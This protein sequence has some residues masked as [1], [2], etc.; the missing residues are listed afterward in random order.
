MVGAEQ[1]IRAFQRE[2]QVVRAMARRV[3]RG[4]PPAIAFDRRAVRQRHIRM[5][6]VVAALPALVRR[7]EESFPARGGAPE[8]PPLPD[9][10][11]VWE[12]RR[13]RERAPL[14]GYA[15]AGGAAATATPAAAVSPAAPAAVEAWVRDAAVPL[16][17]AL[18]G[19]ANL[20]ALEAVA[21]TRLRVELTDAAKYDEDAAK[22][23][24]VVAVMHVAPGVL[25][26]IVG[27]KAGEFASAIKAS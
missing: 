23:S 14:L 24:G 25:H 19:R 15:L 5:E 27:D 9:V 1:D 6:S 2:A 3:D 4:E 26:L 11:L 21:F 12:R 18:G 22:L 7:L 16:L 20:R 8:P 13:R 17:A 10:E